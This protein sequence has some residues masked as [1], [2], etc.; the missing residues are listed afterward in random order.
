[1]TLQPMIQKALSNCPAGISHL[2]G[3]LA[4]QASSDSY[5]IFVTLKGVDVVFKTLQGQ[6]EELVSESHDMTSCRIHL[7]TDLS[8]CLPQD[9][10]RIASS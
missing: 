2:R 4:D 8:S 3:L 1:M 9:G 10:R 5:A 6:I 7:S